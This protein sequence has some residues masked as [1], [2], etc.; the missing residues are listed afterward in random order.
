MAVGS[1]LLLA[2]FTRYTAT[3]WADFPLMVEASARKAPTSARAQAQYAIMLYNVQRYEEALQ[4]L[5]NA[6]ENVPGHRP[7]LLVNRLVMLCNRGM[8]SSN[9]FAAVSGVLSSL[10]YD[11]RS[12]KP[13]LALS[14]AV[15][16]G[17][18]P[19]V[20]P[21][22]LRTMYVNMSQV[23]QNANPQSLGYS[24]IKYYIGLADVHL[25]EPARAV[26]EFE[27]SLQANPRAD[28]AMT[29]AA[30]L[31]TNKYFA[32]ALYLSNKA[33]SQLQA[34]AGDGKPLARVSASTIR[35]FQAAVRIEMDAVR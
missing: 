4:V 29:M 33:L 9:D 7:L 34:D 35:E 24:E 28:H 8:L 10:V 12:V 1:L 23:P 17:H 32:E 11:P 31:A 3:I 25:D 5:D 16:E 2:G 22:D 18:C 6:I 26:V 14:S 27:A 30:Y 21:E 15:L 13:Y 20:S 19:D